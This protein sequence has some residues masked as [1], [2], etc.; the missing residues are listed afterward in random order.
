MDNIDI[1]VKRLMKIKRIRF[2][3][4]VKKYSIVPLVLVSNTFSK[5]RRR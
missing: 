1:A 5:Q 4:K 2:K 3:N